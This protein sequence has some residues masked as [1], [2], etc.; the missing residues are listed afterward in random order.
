MRWRW[1]VL[2]LLL[3]GCGTLPQPFLG[4]PGATGARLAVPPPPILIVPQPVNAML[5]N[6]ASA[7]YAKDLAQALVARDVPS[8][9]RPAAKGEWVLTVTT[10]LSGNQ[11]APDFT[12]TGPNGKAYGKAA[13]V[14]VAAADWAL[15]TP[16]V[17]AANAE[18]AAPA[19]VDQL[20]MINA[21]IEESNPDSLENRPPRVRFTGVTGAPGDGDHALALNVRRDLPQ[22]GIVLTK[23]R[24]D[25]DF[26]LNGVVK[27]TK[28]AG[29]LQEIV[30]LDWVVR[31]TDGRFIGKVS[32]LHNLRPADMTPYWGDVAVAAAREASGGI[33]QVIA[34]AIPKKTVPKQPMRHQSRTAR[35]LVS[36]A[37]PA[38]AP[39]P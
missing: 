14:D 24:A 39:S 5:G 38:A 10:K 6:H 15:A 17:L 26:V 28:S 21:A 37:K 33:R 27:A 31:E 19:L 36:D 25:A 16:S 22:L 13:G 30:E 2:P 7:L 12:I 11:V 29:H 8:L 4:R 20:R 18:A 23:R 34:N 1:V 32:Q 3:A 9:A 35:K